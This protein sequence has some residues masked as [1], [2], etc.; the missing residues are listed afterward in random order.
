MLYI[1][2]SNFET[3]YK[4]SCQMSAGTLY[5]V[6]RDNLTYTIPDSFRE[7]CASLLVTV[8]EKERK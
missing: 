7:T 5:R 4:E 2:D 3:Y 8:G 1:H 6:L